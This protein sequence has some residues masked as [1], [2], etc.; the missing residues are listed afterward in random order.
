MGGGP[1]EGE[2]RGKVGD[3]TS[4]EN[5]WKGSA[6]T[7]VQH[8]VVAG[9]LGPS[10]P[11]HSHTT[12]SPVQ[13]HDAVV[14]IA[15]R[16][17]HRGILPLSTL[18]TVGG[19]GGE[20]IWAAAAGRPPSPSTVSHQPP[21]LLRTPTAPHMHCCS[22]IFACPPAPAVP[23]VPAAPAR[24]AGASRATCTQTPRRRRGCRSP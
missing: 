12:L 21:T 20:A 2:R 1:G 9:F 3:R 5:N 23:S 11:S 24:C 22:H 15:G 4:H 17:Q 14:V 19:Q 10:N 6:A 18:H 7:S 13:R 8:R 16:Q